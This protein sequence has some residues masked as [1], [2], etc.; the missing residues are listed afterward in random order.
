MT[1]YIEKKLVQNNYK[2][3]V[4]DVPNCLWNYVKKGDETAN[5]TLTFD[6]ELKKWRLSY[7]IKNHR[8]NYAVYFE[9]FSKLSSYI[10]YIIAN[11]IIQ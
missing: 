5:T 6:Y 10:D 11:N 7:P 9:D 8:I 2:E 3:Y 1:I 4:D